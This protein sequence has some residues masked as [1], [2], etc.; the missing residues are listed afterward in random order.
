MERTWLGA[1]GAGIEHVIVGAQVQA[2][3]V[4]DLGLHRSSNRERVSTVRQDDVTTASVGLHAAL[5]L[6]L[7]EK[8]RAEAGIRGDLYAF[9]VESDN[10]LNSGE[11]QAGTVSPKLS[12]IYSPAKKTEVYFNGGYGFHSNDARGTVI[13]VDPG[14][15]DPVDRVDPLV[16]SLGFEMGVRASP[17]PGL[18]TTISWWLLDSDSELVFVGDAGGTEASEATRRQGVEIANFYRVGSW[19]VLD[20]DLA[21]TRARYRNSPGDDRIA[22]SISRVVTAGATFNFADGWSAGLRVRHFGSQ[23][24]IE[25]NSVRNASSVSVN[26][27]VGFN[28]G[29]WRVE[30]SV[31]NL[32][33]RENADIAYFYTSRL[34][35]EPADGVEDVHFHPAEPRTFRLSLSRTF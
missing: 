4:D 32:L 15:G 18:V 28:L 13:R 31:L 35:G 11:R 24:L 21:L 26:A 17:L 10:P 20:A 16:S 8:L 12:V 9:E 2:D 3:L 22:N 19:L 29:K 34:P 33:D 30:G 14:S 6:R 25:D 27:Q 23:P 7:A 1:P 5:R